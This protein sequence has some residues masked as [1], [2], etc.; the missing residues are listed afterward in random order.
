[1]AAED[2]TNAPIFS[3]AKTGVAPASEYEFGEA[4]N[5]VFAALARAMSFVGTAQGVMGAT[6]FAVSIVHVWMGGAPA[7]VSSLPMALT[8]AMFSVTGVWLRRASEPIARIVSTKGSD[9]RNLMAAMADLAQMFSLQRTYFIV[10]GALA[11]VSLVGVIVALALFADF[12][13]RWM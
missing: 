1:M 3:D 4:E 11:A 7:L 2:L 10:T 9:I 5:R 12:V 13:R 6:L 8:G